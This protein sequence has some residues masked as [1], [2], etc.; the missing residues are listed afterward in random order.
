MLIAQIGAE[1]IPLVPK[2]KFPLW[3]QTNMCVYGCA[4]DEVI[5]QSSFV[6]PMWFSILREGNL[7]G[8]SFCI[9]DM[10]LCAYLCIYRDENPIQR[11]LCERRLSS[12]YK[13]DKNRAAYKLITFYIWILE[14]RKLRSN[15][16][17]LVAAAMHRFF[18][19]FS[20]I[21]SCI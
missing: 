9:C 17:L 7:V 4:N 16:I 10:H 20:R 18:L 8:I 6:A 5:R 19:R 1:S 21:Y 2:L 13:R 14:W 15:N 3:W 12:F 11:T